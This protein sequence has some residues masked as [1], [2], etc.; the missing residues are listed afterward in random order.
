MLTKREINRR[1]FWGAHEIVPQLFRRRTMNAIV[2]QRGMDEHIICPR[3]KMRECYRSNPPI[4]ISISGQHSP[5]GGAT[6]KQSDRKVPGPVWQACLTNLC[7]RVDSGMVQRIANTFRSSSRFPR[8][9]GRE[10]ISWV[11]PSGRKYGGW[12]GVCAHIGWTLDPL[13]HCTIKLRNQMRRRALRIIGI[14]ATSQLNG[15]ASMATSSFHVPQRGCY[16][17][18]FGKRGTS[19]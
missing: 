10:G 9:C 17:C 4:F 6:P 14:D 19:I 2:P 1:P 11:H 13:S 15:V 8:F 18:G 7:P 16:S 5:C 12:G 3:M